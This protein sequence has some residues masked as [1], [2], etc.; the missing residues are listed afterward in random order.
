MKYIILS[1]LIWLSFL[2][3]CS[4]RTAQTDADIAKKEID[5]TIILSP[6]TER[7]IIYTEKAPKPVGP[8]SQAIFK[9]NTLYV[10]GQIG[11]DPQTSKLVGDSVDVQ[12][13][14]VLENIKAI[15][16]AAGLKLS[17]VVQTTVYLSNINDFDKMNKVYKEYFSGSAPARATV[18]VAAIPLKAKVEIVAIAAK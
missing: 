16:E 14:K 10:A 1:I 15:V 3:A 7:K 4:P 17:D 12:T 11:I 8:Y 9:N 2:I 6:S 5:T 18:E 13:R